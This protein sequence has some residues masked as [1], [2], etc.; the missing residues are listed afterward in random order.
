[1]LT[2]KADFF[3]LTSYKEDVK[4]QRVFVKSFGSSGS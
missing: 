4:A 2:K 3:I 1:M